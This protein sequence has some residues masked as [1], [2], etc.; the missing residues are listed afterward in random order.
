MR[1]DEKS[2]TPAKVASVSKLSAKAECKSYKTYNIG[3]LELQSKPG[4]NFPKNLQRV[5]AA[6]DP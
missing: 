5:V 4:E 3:G 1:G 6:I 2:N